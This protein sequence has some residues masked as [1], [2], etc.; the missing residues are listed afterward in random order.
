M[1]LY[2]HTSPSGKVYIGI[3]RDVNIRWSNKGYRYLTYNSIFGKAILKYGWDNI[4]HEILFTKLSK[5]RAQRLEIELIRHYKNLGISY[6]ITD[7]GEGT[8]GRKVSK[9]TREKMQK[10]AHGW[11][12][13]AI[14][15]SINSL[16]RKSRENLIKARKAWKG[17][18]HSDST[19]ETMS[20][21]AKGRDMTKA[22]SES[23]KRNSKAV[24]AILLDGSILTFN[25]ITEASKLLKVNRSNI[26]RAIRMGYKVNKIEFSYVNK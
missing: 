11:S 7:G 6:N 19:K 8:T 26:S 9:S 13:E 5:D 10:S 16:N 22:V 14:Q 18:H 3:T 4:K 2:R 1:I 21:K 25:S 20:I 12:K 15:A 24:R 17:K 23:I